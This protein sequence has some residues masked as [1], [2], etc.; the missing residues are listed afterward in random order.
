MIL[1]DI[2]VAPFAQRNPPT[3]RMHANFSSFRTN[4]L[5]RPSINLEANFT[6]RAVPLLKLP[7]IYI[8]IPMNTVKV[9]ECNVSDNFFHAYIWISVFWNCAWLVE[10][11]IR[12]GNYLCVCFPGKPGFFMF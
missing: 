9:P 2:K 3:T 4:S 1:K 7:T 10:I 6:D 12:L 8:G 5:N 11:E